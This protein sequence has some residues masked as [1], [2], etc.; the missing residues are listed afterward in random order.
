MLVAAYGAWNVGVIGTTGARTG[1]RQCC[2]VLAVLSEHRTKV[3]A[4]I[5]SLLR[6]AGV[7]V[8]E[9]EGW[10]TRKRPGSWRPEFVVWHHTAG[11]KS[12]GVV[13]NGRPDLAG[14]L[15]NL[16]VPKSGAVNLVSAGRCN[17]A[18]NGAGQA[19][20]RVRKNL[21]PAGDAA[22][23]GWL[24]AVNGN[25]IS[26]GVECENLGDGRDP[27]PDEQLN[28]MALVGALLSR[29]HSWPASRHIAHREWTR[30]KPDP[31]GFSMV[32]FRARVR[33]LLATWGPEPTPAPLH[34]QPPQPVYWWTD[35]EGQRMRTEPIVVEVDQWGRGNERTG[36]AFEKF[37]SI[38][39]EAGVVPNQAGWYPGDPGKPRP[40]AWHANEDEQITVIAVG[41][42]APFP[43]TVW[44]TTR[45]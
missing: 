37:V 2:S 24:D 28:T 4:E 30:R 12:L 34:S 22:Q 23:L 13:V 29:S 9:V 45:D 42:Q 17:H 43:I 21:D 7:D 41:G 5:A 15:A 40:E 31:R 14:P 20:A 36:I 1:R 18:G 32:E 38:N 35:P 39:A 44:L 27:W 26:Y 11:T 25:G 6:D 33:W 19:L 16:H 3:V 8:T 10:R